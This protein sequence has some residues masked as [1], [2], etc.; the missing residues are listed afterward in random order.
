MTVIGAIAAF[1]EEGRIGDAVTS[2]LE[3]GC[4]RV[5]VLDGAWLDPFGQP[6][7]GGTLFSTDATA[8]EAAAAGA[9]VL[10]LGGFEG[11]DAGKQQALV[12]HCDA[13]PGDFIVRIDADERLRGTLPEITGHSL[14]WLHNHGDNDL[15][16]VR[17]TWPRGDDAEHPIPLLRV[18]QFQP[19]L[20]CW[21]PGRWVTGAGELQP[22]LVGA[23]ASLI[24]GAGMRW[25]HPIARAYRSFREREHLAEPKDTA[26]FPI[27]DGVWI[28]HYRDMAKA[29]A[30]ALYYEATA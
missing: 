15:P 4:E 7:G 20:R 11:G 10:V 21:H 5:H 30:K 29:E 26:A 14:V 8:E 13:Q 18:L 17:S 23:L 22:Y 3:A 25:E 1:M 19:D 6:F 27:L 12:H 28:D 24:D 2:L 16:G 9:H